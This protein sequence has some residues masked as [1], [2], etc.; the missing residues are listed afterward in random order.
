MSEH[1]L[2]TGGAR[3]GKSAFAEKIA[4]ELGENEVLYVATAAICDEEMQERVR[5]HRASRP[6]TWETLE[7]YC[8][9]QN[10][11]TNA[12][13]QKATVI[14]VDCIGFMLNNI[15]FELVKDGAPCTSVVMAEVEQNMLAE[16]KL[17]CDA[18][19]RM[20]KTM[21]FVTNEIGLGIVPADRL[22]RY[23]RDILGR[24]NQYLAA[25]ANRV[26]FLISGIALPI[27]E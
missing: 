15:L 18:G 4:W 26:Y 7:Q 20:D 6:Q 8:G 10:L 24:C 22:S 2:V 13:F 17:L 12:D 1:I 19:K 3:S 23:Y 5:K 11:D 25:A 16:L 21:I 27:K 14:L 9:F